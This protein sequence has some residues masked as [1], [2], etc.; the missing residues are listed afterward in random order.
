MR[1]IFT[2]GLIALCT[3]PLLSTDWYYEKSRDGKITNYTTYAFDKNV[4]NSI[5]LSCDNEYNELIIALIPNIKLS[6]R[7]YNIISYKFDNKPKLK[8]NALYNSSSAY[9]SSFVLNEYKQPTDK[10]IKNVAKMLKSSKNVKIGLVSLKGASYFFNIDLSGS[11]KKINQ[12][13]KNC[14]Y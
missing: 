2:I 8:F 9:I 10:T 3:T 12:V 11:S 13:L 1:K 14:N 4:N 7:E 5:T 6:A